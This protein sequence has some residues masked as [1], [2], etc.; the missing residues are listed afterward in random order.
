MTHIAMNEAALEFT[1]V[2]GTRLLTYGEPFAGKT[3]IAEKKPHF[4]TCCLFKTTTRERMCIATASLRGFSD[5][6]LWESGTLMP[7]MSPLRTVRQSCERVVFE[8]RDATS[9]E[10][11][12]RSWLVFISLLLPI[13][14]PA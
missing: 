6:L 7:P 14:A 9:L 10:L 3:V 5:C 8:C 12:P 11:I 4:L 1:A 13:T 2:I